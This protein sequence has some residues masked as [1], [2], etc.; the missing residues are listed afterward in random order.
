MN[1]LSALRNWVSK[2]FP[3]GRAL[4]HMLRIKFWP[5]TASGRAVSAGGEAGIANPYRRDR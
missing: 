3:G 4:A 2:H 1:P 5:I